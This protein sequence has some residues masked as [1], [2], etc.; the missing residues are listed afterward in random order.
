MCHYI[1][2][3]HLYCFLLF[4]YNFISFVDR[5]H[6]GEYDLRNI[7]SIFLFECRKFYSLRL[8]W[9][10]HM[11]QYCLKKIQNRS[12]NTLHLGRIVKGRSNIVATLRLRREVKEILTSFYNYRIKKI[13]FNFILRHFKFHWLPL[14]FLII[15]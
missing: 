12:L 8:A 6:I 7:M 9:N 13:S 3:R 11:L 1:L 5:Y 14:L 2:N 4:I 10:G 15:L